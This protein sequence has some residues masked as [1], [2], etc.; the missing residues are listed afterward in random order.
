MRMLG[1]IHHTQ[2]HVF[3]VIRLSRGDE[4]ETNLMWP[5]IVEPKLEERGFMV[6]AHCY[7]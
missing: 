6:E 5:L 7:Y 1:Y 3:D 4:S 2:N